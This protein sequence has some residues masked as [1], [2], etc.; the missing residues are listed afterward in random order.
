MTVLAAMQKTAV[1]LI[2]RKP[3]TFFTAQGNFEMEMVTLL[4]DV[5]LEISRAHDWR[6][7]TKIHTLIGDGTTTSFAKPDDYDRMVIA[8]HVS[9]GNSWFWNYELCPDLDTWIAIQNGY[10]LGAVPPGWWMLL[11][12]D[13]QFAPAPEANA[14]AIFPYVSRHYARAQNGTPKAEFTADTDTFVL[15]EELLTLGLKWKWRESKHLDATGDQAD[16]EKRFSEA[17][18]RDPGARVI[19]SRNQTR[20]NFRV[21]WPWSLG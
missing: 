9:D 1:P 10:Y 20:R 5:A 15:D 4:N 3:Q 13:F 6:D 16:F 8:S 2:G 18:A 21:A 11:D 17:S 12:G 7:L 14:R 19:R